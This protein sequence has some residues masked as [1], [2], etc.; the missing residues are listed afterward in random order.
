MRFGIAGFGI[1]GEGQEEGQ[2]EGEGGGKGAE[3]PHGESSCAAVMCGFS[4]RGSSVFCWVAD[5]C[6]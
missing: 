1:C 6:V 4:A 2:E 5:M 3:E